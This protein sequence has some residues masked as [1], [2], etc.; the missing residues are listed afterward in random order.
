MM[1]SLVAL[2]R[3]NVFVSGAAVLAL[4]G[5]GSLLGPSGPPAQIYRL[6]PVFP[7][8]SPGP[9]VS[10]QLAVA[11]P[12]SSQTLDTERIALVRGAAMD[13]F[14][15]AQ[16]NDSVPRLVQALLVDAFER[17]GRILAVARESEGVRADYMIETEIRDFDAQYATENGAPTVVVDIMARLLGAHGA[18]IASRNV[19]LSQPAGAN[20]VANVVTAFDQALGATLEQV[21]DWTLQAPAPAHSELR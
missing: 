11:R 14:A 15:D 2:T 1:P 10:W 21:V 17:S 7:A 16:W 8:P 6:D 13:Y 9:P 5:C 3:R 12:L 18:V 19:R 4:G 20:S